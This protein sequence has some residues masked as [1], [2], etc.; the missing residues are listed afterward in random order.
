MWDFEVVRKS[1]L[2]WVWENDNTADWQFH[3]SSIEISVLN[4]TAKQRLF[5]SE[6]IVCSFLYLEH[7]VSLNPLAVNRE[8]R[9]VTWAC[10][11]TITQWKQMNDDLQKGIIIRAGLNDSRARVRLISTLIWEWSITTHAKIS[12]G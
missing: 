6:R 4:N 9:G 5:H 3:L 8:D 12:S 10:N 11:P 1:F 7:R 2:Q